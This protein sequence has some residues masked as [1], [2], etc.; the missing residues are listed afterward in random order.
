MVEE[1]NKVEDELERRRQCHLDLLTRMACSKT[2]NLVLGRPSLVPNS[3]A[4]P[5]EVGPRTGRGLEFERGR[6]PRI[7]GGRG[8]L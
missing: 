3:I 7:V 5:G 2:W 6:T 8:V 4:S 1:L